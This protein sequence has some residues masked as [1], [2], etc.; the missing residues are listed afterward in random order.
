[1]K[2][3]TLQRC[4]NGQ[5]LQGLKNK[6]R[7]PFG[8]KLRMNLADDIKESRKVGKPYYGMEKYIVLERIKSFKLNEWNLGDAIGPFDLEA[9]AIKV[10]ELCE[11]QVSI[12]EMQIFDVITVNVL[13][14]FRFLEPTP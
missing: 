9:D 13:N 7:H 5:Y 12:K 1:M 2:K 3:T 11:K 8:W 10:K 4:R 14:K 6:E